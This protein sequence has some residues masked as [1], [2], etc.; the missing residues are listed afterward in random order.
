MLWLM[1]EAHPATSMQWQKKPQTNGFYA[2][3]F[4]LKMLSSVLPWS[5]SLRGLQIQSS[6]STTVS[7]ALHLLDASP[8]QGVTAEDSVQV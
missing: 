7:S 6:L 5:E 3:T 2:P 4:N 1:K 8:L